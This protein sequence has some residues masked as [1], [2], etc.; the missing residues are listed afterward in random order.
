MNISAVGDRKPR[1]SKRPPPVIPV[2]QKERYH[3]AVHEAGHAVAAC[4]IGFG[5]TR[6]GVVLSGREGAAYTRL[7]GRCSHK[8]KIRERYNRRRLV[9]TFAG[10]VAEYRVNEG[11]THI[12][13]DVEDIAL[14]LGELLPNKKRYFEAVIRKDES[15]DFWGL[16]W[17]LATHVRRERALEELDKFPGLAKVDVSLFEMLWPF[18]QQARAI[19]DL[20]WHSVEQMSRHLLKVGSISG[21]EIEALVD[22]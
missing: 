12:D 18:A 13:H 17:I 2:T 6:R 16:I 5:M 9:T 8:P 4:A 11:L 14:A 10:S 7:P 3:C 21:D 15:G 22:A 20:Q 19:I 1:S